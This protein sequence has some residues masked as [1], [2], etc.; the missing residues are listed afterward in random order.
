VLVAVSLVLFVVTM[1][2]AAIPATAFQ[3]STE[4]PR[5]RQDSLE[6][7]FKVGLILAR[8]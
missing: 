1:M 7:Y 3:L 5:L 4:V 8:T 2:S 6:C